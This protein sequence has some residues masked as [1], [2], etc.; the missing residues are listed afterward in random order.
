MRRSLMLSL[1]LV[2]L[3]SCSDKPPRRDLYGNRVD[4]EADW[5]QAD[6]CTTPL[7]VDTP[8]PQQCG[9]AT[10]LGPSYTNRERTRLQMNLSDS[11][12]SL[13]TLAVDDS[14]VCRGGFGSRGQGSGGG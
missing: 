4:C 12:R 8:L 13:G 1:V 10:L 7:A 11:N 3:T 5:A 14:V 6:R 2:G 9:S